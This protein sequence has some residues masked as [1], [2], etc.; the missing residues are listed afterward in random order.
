MSGGLFRPGRRLCRP[1]DAGDVVYQGRRHLGEGCEVLLLDRGGETLVKK[2]SLAQ[3]AR[4][5]GWRIGDAVRIDARGRLIDH[6]P[7][8]EQN[9][10]RA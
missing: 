7:H 2:V 3:A 1:A 4:A 9:A 5:S 8:L 10:G 6:A